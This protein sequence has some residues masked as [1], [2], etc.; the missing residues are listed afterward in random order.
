MRKTDPRRAPSL[1]ATM[2][3]PLQVDQLPA[4]REPDAEPRVRARLTHVCLAEALED[5]RH[6][7]GRDA[8]SVV[9][10]LDLQAPVA[11]LR[12][13]HDPP[14]RGGELRRVRKE[15]PE[16]LL[17]PPP[18]EPGVAERRV[19][20][21][22][23]RQPLRLGGR[24]DH[25]ERGVNDGADVDE[26]R[27]EAHF[28]RREARQLQQLLDEARLAL[29]ALGDRPDR[30]V[31][32]VRR[33]GSGP[34]RPDPQEYGGER[35]AQLV[36]QRRQELVLRAARL[37]GLRLRLARASLALAQRRE[38]VVLGGVRLPELGFDPP[39]D[40]VLLVLRPSREHRVL[41]QVQRRA[42][43]LAVALS[44]GDERGE[45]VGEGVVVG[46]EAQH[47]R[48][49]RLVAPHEVDELRLRRRPRRSALHEPRSGSV[50]AG[51]SS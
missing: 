24:P 41:H 6:E 51:P 18:V 11:P 37:L 13:K 45:L 2:L 48:A 15:V 22:V 38:Q 19:H 20:R 47:L 21:D 30:A 8:L 50:A 1:A 14:P 29:G 42:A 25:L 34:H 23:E 49:E 39:P 7:L 35:R 28:S 40:L 31:E 44:A 17:Q 9:A 43:A 5:V 32:I 4:E 10:D 3:P 33:D 26:R 16:D 46:A 12:A 36:A 27:H